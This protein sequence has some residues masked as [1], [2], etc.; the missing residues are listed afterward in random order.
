EDAAKRHLQVLTAEGQNEAV[1]NAALGSWVTNHYATLT[2][3]GPV[4][5]VPASDVPTLTD[6]FTAGNLTQAH[7]NGP[8][9]GGS[10]V[11]SMSVGPSTCTVSA[12]DCHVTYV[13]YPSAPVTRGGKPDVIGASQI[14]QA[15]GNA[16]GFSRV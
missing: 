3:N 4:D 16:F 7:A 12:G 9:W 14:A 5:V 11:I 1:I 8:F 2:Q 15:G 6:L 10:Y 13:M